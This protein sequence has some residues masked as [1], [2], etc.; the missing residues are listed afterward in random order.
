MEEV[1]NPKSTPEAISVRKS[2][3]KQTDF[4]TY[5]IWKEKWRESCFKRVREDRTRLLWESRGKSLDK[6]DQELI[7]SAF[8]GIVSDE[9]NRLRKPS[10]VVDGDEKT[11]TSAELDLD[12][13]GEGDML[14]EYEGLHDAY[15]GDREEILLEMQRIFY[16]DIRAESNPKELKSCIEAWEEEE[17][18]YLARAV[19]EHMQLSDEVRKKIWCPV[20]KQ[21]ELLE[22]PKAIHC[23]LCELQLNKCDEVNLDILESR[24]ANAHTEHFDRGCRQKPKFQ[25]QTRFGLTALY[26][27][28]QDCN[29]FDI[30]I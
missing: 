4:N 14:W 12:G 11:L 29:V 26:L 8:Q 3:K 24:L 30:V 20:C 5:P 6:Q 22:K 21:G 23:T 13:D 7:K 15:Q 2:I 16:E 10:L 17:D 28:C 9:L 1:K 25:I 19:Y 18:E 27:T